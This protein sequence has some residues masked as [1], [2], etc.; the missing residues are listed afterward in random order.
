MNEDLSAEFESIL[1]EN[2]ALKKMLRALED[3]TTA[4]N[5]KMIDAW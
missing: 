3:K 1:V 4:S 5:S 2:D